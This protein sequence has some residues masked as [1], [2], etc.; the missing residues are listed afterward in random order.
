MA[1]DKEKI[2]AFTDGSSRGN[3]G[4]GGWGSVLVFIENDKEDSRVVELGGG[5]R[6]TTNN[7][8]EL[9]A[10]IETLKYILNKEPDKKGLPITVFTDS[11]YLIK[12]VTEWSRSWSKNG[13]MTKGG[14]SVKNTDLWKELLDLVAKIDVSLKHVE[15]HSG[16][17]GNERADEIACRFADGDGFPL[18]ECSFKDYDINLFSLK[19]SFNNNAKNPDKKRSSAKPYSYVSAV[20]GKVRSHQ[21]WEDCRKR[22]HG[23]SG[24]SFKKVYSPEEEEDLMRNWSA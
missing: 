10:V 5:E 7:R 24:A 19:G 1:R 6:N 18:R 11:R 12:G 4:P 20:D 9:K 22:V 14:S 16:V 3:P 21:N 13:W 8:M 17:A 23:V 2:I 15:G